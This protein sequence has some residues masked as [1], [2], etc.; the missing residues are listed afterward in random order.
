MS[1]IQPET[2][3]TAAQQVCCANCHEWYDAR[4]SAC[5]LC[6]Q[7]RP[8]YNAAL[9]NA[10]HTTRLNSAL[11]RQ[12]GVARAEGQIR[13]PNGSGGG[14]GPSTPYNVPGYRDLAASLKSKLFNA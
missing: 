4:A 6:G 10:V 9:A 11:S 1:D 8:D 13:A 7:E 14:A 5:Y 2:I 3:E 12:S